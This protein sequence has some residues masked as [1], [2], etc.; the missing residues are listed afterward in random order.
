MFS[1]SALCCMFLDVGVVNFRVDPSAPESKTSI[2]KY[3]A[4][5][6]GTLK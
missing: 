3:G 4:V 5:R 2:E 6:L 1:L